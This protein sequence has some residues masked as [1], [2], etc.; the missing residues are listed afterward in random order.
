MAFLGLFGNYNRPGP[1]VSKDEP[2][3]PPYIRYFQLMGR[4]YGKLMQLNLLFLVPFVIAVALMLVLFFFFPHFSLRVGIQ[5]DLAVDINLWF[6]CVVPI[7]LFL[8]SPFWAGMTYVTRNFA[9]EEHAFVFSDFM[10]AVK[11]N[12]KPFLLNG[13]V[14]YIAWM[15]LSF[16]MIYYYYQ[17]AFNSMMIIPFALCFLI[18]VILLFCQYYIP[19][20]IVTFDLP[21]RKIYRNALIFAII[22]LW[23]NLLLTIIFGAVLF[24]FSAF[25]TSLVTIVIGLA[26]ILLCLFS[27]VSYSTNFIVYPLVEKL[28]IQ[29]YYNNQEK[30]EENKNDEDEDKEIENEQRGQMDQE[31]KPEYVYVNGRL[32]KR[33]LVE[34]EQVFTDKHE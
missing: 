23:R 10:D 2:K 11:N 7:P 17:T 30:T 16:S 19:L 34:D 13:L 9:R 22:G 31:D 25:F 26:F 12:W 32:I 29:P 4:K 28:M 24:L 6:L 18:A 21:L 14:L 20:M 15:L 1:G 33:T 5:D 27:F 8:I 3:K